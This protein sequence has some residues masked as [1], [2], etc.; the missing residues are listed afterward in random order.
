[1]LPYLTQREREE[2]D[3]LLENNHLELARRS[4]LDF[5][6][7]TKPDYEV[8][9]HHRV[10]CSYLDKF[11]EGEIKRLMLFMPPRYGKSELVSRRL[12]AYIFGR[13]PEARI[14]ACSYGDTLASM[15]NRD[16]QRIIDS[17]EYKRV[18]PG[19]AL[20]GANVRTTAQ[21]SWL[22]NSDIFEIVNHEGYYRSA[23]VGSGVTGMGMMYGIID[24]PIKN[25]KE[26]N[27]ETFRQAIWEWYTSTF[28]TRRAPGAGILLTVT[29]W[30]EDDL[31]GKL[32][33]LA[34]GDPEADQWTVVEFPALGEWDEKHPQAEDDPREP[35]EA[36]WP[37]RYDLDD[38]KATRVN[39][40]SYDWYSVYQQRPT[41]PEGGMFKRHWFEVVGVAPRI[42]K[43]VRAWDKAGSDDSGDYTVGLLMA[44]DSKGV[45]YVEDVVRGQFSD[46]E[47]E[48]VIKQTAA[49]DKAKYGNV[50]VWIEQ[51]PGSGGKDSARITIRNLAGHEVRAERPTTDKA[52]RAGPYAAQCEA[53][54]VKLV[55]GDWNTAYLNEL[56]GFPY[57]THDDQVDASSLAFNKLTLEPQIPA[58]MDLGGLTQISRW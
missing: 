48:T 38:L 15:M 52:T 40:G 9:W 24:D 31:A 27:S 18:F 28:Y 56:A 3:L 50:T 20:S 55:A 35:G 32:L 29:R 42:A 5:T 7:Y 47:R 8:N 43:R 36:L 53:E 11:V 41:P 33:A 57:G 13:N 44:R 46:L 37:E 54:N 17:D 58:N 19:T 12:P 4:L 14:I 45:Y 1:M 25:R 34:E 6:T 39:V 49:A 10:V 23:G 26:A 30:H 22:R 51:E 21:G 16:V 2:L